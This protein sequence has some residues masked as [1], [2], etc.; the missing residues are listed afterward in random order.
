VTDRAFRLPILSFT[1]GMA[2]IAS[3]LTSIATQSRIFA[4]ILADLA[5]F[6]ALPP[7]FVAVGFLLFLGGI[8]FRGIRESMW[9]NVTCTLMEVS[10]LLLVIVTGVSYWGT[11]DYFE[12][13]AEH[14]TSALPVVVLQASVL[15]FFAFIGFEDA[16]NVA[17][18]CKEP[19]RTVPRGLIIATFS[20]A[21]LYIAVAVT[22]VSVVPWQ[23]LAEAPS[24]LTEVLRRSAPSVPPS[25]MSFIALFSVANTALVNYVTASR[26]IYGMAD[27]GLLPK[28]LATVHEVRRTPHIAI[29]ALMI[30]LLLLVSSGDIADLAAATVLLLLVV[31]IAVNGALIVLKRRAGEAPGQF[32]VPLVLPVAGVFVCATLLVARLSSLDWRAPALATLILLACLGIFAA[33]RIVK[34]NAE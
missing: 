7:S 3:G 21:V 31:F 14:A 25:L 10:G 17:E 27:Q 33:L 29:A 5:G 20:A 24:P 22:A 19:E 28:G 4:A 34:P 15:A 11:V 12:T 1:V 2:L 30:V 26:L 6:D 18:E 8:V 13:P 23:T 9:V 16:I 32:E